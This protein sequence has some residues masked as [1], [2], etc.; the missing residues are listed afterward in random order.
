MSVKRYFCVFWVL[1][2]CLFL[3]CACKEGDPGLIC[4]PSHDEVSSSVLSDGSD[5]SSASE[6]SS[7]VQSVQPAPSD[8]LTPSA[9][10]APTFSESEPSASVEPSPEPS[11]EPTPTPELTPTPTPTPTP[12][13]ED[14]TPWLLKETKDAGKDYQDSLI[15]L[16]DSTTAH[17]V[18]HGVLTG[19]EQTKQVWMG[20]SGKT[21]TYKYMQTV[22]IIY[23]ETGEQMLILDAV[24]KAK[25]TYMVITLGVTG[26]VSMDLTEKQ[27]KDLYFWLLDGIKEASPQTTVIVQSMYPVAKVSD[28]SKWI[29]NE[30]IVRYNGWIEELVADRHEKGMGVYYADTY[31]ALIGSD[32]YL[33]VS[34]GVGDGL[35]ISQKGYEVILNYL[36]SHAVPLQK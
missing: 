22:K 36:R 9:S 4:F 25:P 12:S 15:F 27:F 11:L 10:S 24:K 29:T 28:Y 32:G 21:I 26:G 13:P 8:P 20:S 6:G 33:P 35:H 7:F 14:E 17:M 3:L 30:K 5:G 19:G 1:M 31:S 2:L 23:P 18:S 16:G 34:Y